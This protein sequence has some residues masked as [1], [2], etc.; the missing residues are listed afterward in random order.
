MR[1]G[2]LEQIS[3]GLFVHPRRGRFGAVP[4]GDDDVMNALLD[5]APFVFTGPERW[6]AL[7]LGS[8]AVF[9][10]TLVYNTKRSGEFVLGGRRYRLRRVRFPA[11]PTPE[12]F[13]VDLIEHVE[14]AGV[15]R[16]DLERALGRA[17]AVHR[18]ELARLRQAAHEYGTRATSAF[19]ERATSRSRA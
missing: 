3:H 19:V 15:S 2:S 7:G 6:N 16:A 8:T 1:E 4:P 17:L 5:G 18:F 12:W 11:E 13:V 9:A 10:A 14:M